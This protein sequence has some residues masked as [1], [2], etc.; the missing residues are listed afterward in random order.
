MQ[1]EFIQ[2][3]AVAAV[4]VLEAELGADVTARSN[5]PWP[6]RNSRPRK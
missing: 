2:P 1:V 6:M 5:F 4:R 3:F